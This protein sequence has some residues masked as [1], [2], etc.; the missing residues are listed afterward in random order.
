MP[1]LIVGRNGVVVNVVSAPV[2]AAGDGVW[3]VPDAQVVNVGDVFDPKD[4]QIDAMD[5]AAFRA[6]FRLEN[7][8]RQTI[9]ASS[10]AANSAATSAGLP[11]TAN[12]ADLTLAQARDA[13][14][15]LL[16]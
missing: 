16:P 6:L 3:S 2:N 11:T 5:V 14:K 12:S 15:A 13:F 8:A 10:T 9:R 1:K 4:P 7:L